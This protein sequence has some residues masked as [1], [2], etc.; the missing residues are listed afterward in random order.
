MFYFLSASVTSIIVLSVT[1]YE[2]LTFQIPIILD[3]ISVIFSLTVLL[4][5]SVVFSFGKYYIPLHYSTGRF[6]VVLYLFVF[7]ILILIF[8][9]NLVFLIIGWDGLGIT[10]YLLI[11]F[12]QS[13]SANRARIL[14]VLTNRIGDVA[15]LVTIALFIP[16]GSWR[17]FKLPAVTWLILLAG[18]TKSAQIPFSR[19]LP[20]AMAAPTPVSALVHSSTLVTAGVYLLIRLRKRFSSTLLLYLRIT[21]SVTILFAR[22]SASFEVDLKKIIALSTLRQLGLIMFALSLGLVNLALFH[23]LTHALF[24]SLLF[25]GAGFSIISNNHRQDT[26]LVGQ[27]SW[28]V[29]SMVLSSLALIA[30]PF[31]S[32]YYSKHEI[33]VTALSSPLNL[34]LLLV[35]ITAS[36]F[37]RVYSIKLFLCLTRIKNGPYFSYDNKLQIHVLFM[38]FVAIWGGAAIWWI[39]VPRTF[40]VTPLLYR[41]LLILIIPLSVFFLSLQF[42]SKFL[43]RLWFLGYILPAWNYWILHPSFNIL[44]V[45]DIGWLEA[46][47]KLPFAKIPSFHSFLFMN[48]IIP[49]LVLRGGL[50]ILALCRNS[51]FAPIL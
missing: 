10:S 50:F 14:T 38:S 16:F 7:S 47:S 9:P 6:R 23:L 42:G 31:L 18:L 46:T 30:A 26:R 1:I 4:I 17:F 44:K 12:Y 48:T 21:A 35:V 15:L 3:F 40:I 43:R 19:W 33:L 41:A 27:F 24:K 32:G 20:A 39:V 34:F 5:A 28:T 13:S 25:V 22:L 11:A 37:T 29:Y 8:I 51:N 49:V 45:S 2:N 36:I